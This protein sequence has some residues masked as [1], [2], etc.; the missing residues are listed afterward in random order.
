MLS[1]ISFTALHYIAILCKFKLHIAKTS[2]TVVF[3]LGWLEW[4]GEWF[5]DAVIHGGD[6]V[7]YDYGIDSRK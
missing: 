7:N 4:I 5:V 3:T 6:V 1:S 2:F